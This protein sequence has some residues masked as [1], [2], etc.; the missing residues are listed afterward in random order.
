M[1]SFG[2]YEWDSCFKIQEYINIAQ[3]FVWTIIKQPED[4][5]FLTQEKSE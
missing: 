1:R 2:K 3:A 4:N 5:L